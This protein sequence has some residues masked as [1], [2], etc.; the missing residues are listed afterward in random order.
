MERHAQSRTMVFHRQHIDGDIDGPVRALMDAGL[1]AD[2][3]LC[4]DPIVN[5]TGVGK[6]LQYMT[7]CA[8]CATC[9]VA[10]EEENCVLN[11]C[12]HTGPEARRRPQCV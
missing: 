4:Q 12:T 7:V 1:V 2:D 9:K 5:L 3:V 11:T 10:E 6:W 8:C